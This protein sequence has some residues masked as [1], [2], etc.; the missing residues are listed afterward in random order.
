MIATI[1]LGGSLLRVVVVQVL[2]SNMF[3]EDEASALLSFGTSHRSNLCEYEW[4]CENEILV[5]LLYFSL[6]C[7]PFL[8]FSLN[9]F[10]Q[11]SHYH[12]EP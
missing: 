2:I 10:F 5:K 3:S 11:E 4:V 1:P 12:V 8:F 9:H 6:C 7:L